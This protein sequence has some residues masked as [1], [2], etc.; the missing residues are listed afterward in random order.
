MTP[1][2]KHQLAGTLVGQA[3]VAPHATGSWG[4]AVSSMATGVRE[5]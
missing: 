5:G 2:A 3:A 4:Q 1:E